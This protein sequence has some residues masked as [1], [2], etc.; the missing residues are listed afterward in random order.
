M[1][2]VP[3]VDSAVPEIETSKDSQGTENMDL[4]KII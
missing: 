1:L 2:D 3:C 4:Y